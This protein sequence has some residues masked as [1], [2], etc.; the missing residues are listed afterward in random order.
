MFIRI[1]FS[2]EK[3][4]N[5]EMINLVANNPYLQLTFGINLWI[6][7]KKFHYNL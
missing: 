2:A 7:K 3:L 5:F 4:I 1:E 6:D